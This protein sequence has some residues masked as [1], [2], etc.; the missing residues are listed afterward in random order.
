MLDPFDQ[1]DQLSS[2]PVLVETGLASR[3]REDGNQMTGALTNCRPL[4]HLSLKT[5]DEGDERYDRMLAFTWGFKATRLSTD[6]SIPVI[7]L[8][9]TRPSCMC[10]MQPS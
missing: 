2:V 5:I 1:E 8:A 7:L 9:V 10:D 6:S 3:A 4:Q